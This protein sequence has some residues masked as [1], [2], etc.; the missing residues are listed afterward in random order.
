M[1][2]K[3]LSRCMDASDIETFKGTDNTVTFIVD[4]EGEEIWAL[5][6]IELC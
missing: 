4:L 5:V 1:V 6:K 2:I 3:A